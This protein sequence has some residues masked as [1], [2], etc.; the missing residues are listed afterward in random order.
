MHFRITFYLQKILIAL[1]GEQGHICNR[2][3]HLGK[4]VWGAEYGH[5]YHQEQ[6]KFSWNSNSMVWFCLQMSTVYSGLFSVKL[7]NTLIR[8]N[9]QMQKCTNVLHSHHNKWAGVHLI[10]TGMGNSRVQ[11]LGLAISCGS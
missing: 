7:I 11:M 4:Q 8:H 2:D 5:L 10:T 1:N 3:H 9:P 6:S